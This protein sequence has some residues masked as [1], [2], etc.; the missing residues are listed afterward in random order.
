MRVRIS[1]VACASLGI[2]T[3]CEGLLTRLGCSFEVQEMEASPDLRI[4]AVFVVGHC[5]ATVG[6]SSV[7]YL[8]EGGRRIDPPTMRKEDV[9][10]GVDGW[11]EIDLDWAGPNQLTVTCRDVTKRSY[12]RQ[13]RIGEV[14]IVFRDCPG[15]GQV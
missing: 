6:Y 14:E 10:F 1:L 5:G 9:V 7:V 15:Q 3:G 2:I 12:K 11:Q 8:Q 4:T 13:H